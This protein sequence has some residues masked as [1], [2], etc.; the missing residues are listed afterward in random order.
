LHN[1]HDYHRVAPGTSRAKLH[2]LLIGIDRQ[3]GGCRCTWR[4]AVGLGC[5]RRSVQP[6]FCGSCF[7]GNAHSAIVLI[8]TIDI[9][10]RVP[11]TIV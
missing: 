5:T 7:H 3:T 4:P 11:V 2:N 9:E 1:L 10:G 6:Q 8:C